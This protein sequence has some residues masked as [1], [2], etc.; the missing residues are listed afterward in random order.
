M[1]NKKYLKLL[2]TTSEVDIILMFIKEMEQIAEAR[3]ISLDEGA[4]NLIT[5]YDNKYE[6]LKDKANGK[7]KMSFKQTFWKLSNNV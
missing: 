3:S 6:N 1:K 2:D 5:E 7:L 4:N